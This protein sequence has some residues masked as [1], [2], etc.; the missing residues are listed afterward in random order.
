MT[1][2]IIYNPRSGDEMQAAITSSPPIY[3]YSKLCRVFANDPLGMLNQLFYNKRNALILLQDPS[4]MHS[5]HWLGMS[6]H[7]EKKSIYFFSSYGGKPDKEKNEWLSDYSLLRSNQKE[8]VINDALKFLHLR[9]WHVHYNDFP[10]QKEG[11]KTATCGIWTA[12]FLNSGL[13]PD[14]FFHFTSSNG[15]TVLDYYNK[16]FKKE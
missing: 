14:E 16:Y 9:G 7:P 11:D 2:D 5:G 8:N 12:A 1:D 13:N 3:L 6:L 4:N 10:Y 15:L